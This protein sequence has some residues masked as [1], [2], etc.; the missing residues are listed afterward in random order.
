MSQDLRIR[1]TPPKGKV[2]GFILTWNQASIMD[3]QERKESRRI[4]FS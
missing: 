4:K 3:C 2:T 1:I